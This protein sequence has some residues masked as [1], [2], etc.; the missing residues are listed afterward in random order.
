MVRAI[1]LVLLLLGCS[2]PE[3]FVPK[4]EINPPA[5]W[6]DYCLRHKL[7]VHCKEPGEH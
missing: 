7:D 4:T 1:I 6:V 5:G 2:A 3:P